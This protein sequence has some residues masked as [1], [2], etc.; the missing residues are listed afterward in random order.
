LFEDAAMHAVHGWL[1][2]PDTV[3]GVRQRKRVQWRIDFKP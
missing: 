2:S 1:F 3:N